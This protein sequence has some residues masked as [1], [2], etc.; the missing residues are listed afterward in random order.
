MRIYLNNLLL[1]A[2]GLL[3]QGALAQ[4][5]G[6]PFPASDETAPGMLSLDSEDDNSRFVR[7]QELVYANRDGQDLKLK[8]IQPPGVAPAFAAP[9]QAAAVPLIIYVQGSAWFYQDNFATLPRMAQFVQDS[10]FAVASVQYRPS[11]DAIAP[12]Q[13]E[14]VKSAIRFM[15]ANA[16]RYGVDPE[17]F[18][19]WGDSSGGHMAAMAGTTD[20]SDFVTPDN[21]DVSSAV[22][23]VVDFFGPT[24][25]R[26]MSA[27]PS[28][29][30]H[31]AAD[32]PES[33]VIGGPIQDPENAGRVA[34]YNPISYIDADD[35]LPPFL[36]MHGDRDELVPFNQSVLL[37]QAL[38]DAGQ[39]VTFYKVKGAGHGT[40][41]YTPAVLDIVTAF[42]HAQ[43]K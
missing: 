35:S 30:P 40:R 16:V 23:A 10:G 12:A 38:A 2:S 1:V 11:T 27:Y 25:F 21:A 20:D 41:F 14:D 33:T 29:L 8:L 9:T 34:M 22:K 6:E 31:D 26:Q 37:Y 7:I 19:I 32:S 18:A 5:G 15:R 24:D 17:R 43:L 13:I 3:A 4:F 36:I 39:E 42:L 28:R